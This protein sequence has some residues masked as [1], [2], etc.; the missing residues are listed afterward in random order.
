[1]KNTLLGTC[2]AGFLLVGCGGEDDP[3]DCT[4]HGCQQNGL[5]F[6]SPEGGEIR[7][8]HILL[9]DGGVLGRVHAHFISGQ[10]PEAVPFGFVTTGCR[11]MLNDGWPQK[12]GDNRQY[13]DT[14]EITLTG[15]GQPLTLDLAPEDAT[16]DPYGRDHDFGVTFI[17]DQ[18][19]LPVDRT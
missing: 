2:L 10:T 17:G 8:D 3:G 15:A 6:E 18:N 9:P 19:D 12:Q 16:T 7:L 11:P 13:V 14:G 4:G 1:M 5:D